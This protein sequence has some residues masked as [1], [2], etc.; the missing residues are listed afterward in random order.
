MIPSRIIQ[1]HPEYRLFTANCQNFAQY[2]VRS[3]CP[4]STLC[5]S[6]IRDVLERLFPP[7]SDHGRPIPGAYPRSIT[8]TQ[9]GTFRT[10]NTSLTRSS[11]VGPGWISTKPTQRTPASEEWLLSDKIHHYFE[12]LGGVSLGT[13]V[14]RSELF[15]M[16]HP[17]TK[18][19][20]GGT[21][22]LDSLRL[23]PKYVGIVNENNTTHVNVAIQ[24]LFLIP[25]IRKVSLFVN[26]LTVACLESK[27][28]KALC[29]RGLSWGIARNLHQT[30]D[31]DRPYTS[32]CSPSP[33]RY[34]A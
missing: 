31:F 10:A 29:W 30:P 2:L 18:V 34:S 20:G 1:E 23:G 26:Q 28:E 3:I 16:S 32:P 19:E 21:D 5:P 13:G 11:S 22:L 33:S 9:T 15:K 17:E 6:T 12:S 8:S 4:T 14:D 7:T 25:A 24:T 27:V